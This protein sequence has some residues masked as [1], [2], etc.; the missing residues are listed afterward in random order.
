[1]VR[2]AL[3]SDTLRTMRVLLTRVEYAFAKYY[4]LSFIITHAVLNLIEYF[5]F[6]ISDLFTIA[7][8]LQ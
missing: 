6:S 2:I 5:F 4:F 8:Y 7:I 1:M 3:Q